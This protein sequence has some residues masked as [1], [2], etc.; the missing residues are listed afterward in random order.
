MLSIVEHTIL[1]FKR[2]IR[3]ENIHLCVNSILIGHKAIRLNE[4]NKGVR[5]EYT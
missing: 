4:I 3:E 2:N 1:K 5:R